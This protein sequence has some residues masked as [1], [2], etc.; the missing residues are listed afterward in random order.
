MA[1]CRDG[2]VHRA[3]AHCAQVNAFRNRHRI[4]VAGTDVP[5]PITGFVNLE[6]Q[7]VVCATDARGGVPFFGAH[8]SASADGQPPHVDHRFK[9][10]GFLRRA[11]AASP[12]RKPTPIQ[13]QAI[14]ALL[15]VT[16]SAHLGRSQ[17]GVLTAGSTIAA[18]RS[19]SDAGTRGAGRRADG[20]GQDV[21]LHSPHSAPAQGRPA[22]HAPLGVLSIRMRGSRSL[23]RLGLAARPNRLHTRRNREPRAASA[24]SWSCRPASWPIRSI[25]SS[26]G[27]PGP[28]ASASAY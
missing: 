20:L 2:C 10:R 18:K 25:A 28:A 15:Q 12:Y 11:L 14:P 17:R 22:G 5:P 8:R 26:D 3:G 9:L 4:R 13:M 6:A 21:C 19:P 27:W 1:R 16:S 7:C 23:G 24:R